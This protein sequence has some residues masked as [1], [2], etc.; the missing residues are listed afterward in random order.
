M[1]APE[2]ENGDKVDQF[3]IIGC[4]GEEADPVLAF[5]AP[6]E[7]VIYNMVDDRPVI[8]A[9]K[10]PGGDWKLEGEIVELGIGT[11]NDV[12]QLWLDGE[13]M[14]FRDELR[15]GKWKIT[16]TRVDS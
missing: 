1:G 14:G 10:F 12:G 11:V 15:P 9:R 8:L 7:C 3:T 6:G 5:L 16:A 2:R 4:N 13:Y